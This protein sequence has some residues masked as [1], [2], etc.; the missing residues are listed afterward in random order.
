L[1]ENR[2]EVREF[3]TSRRARLTPDRV[4]LPIDLSGRDRRV[5]GLRRSEVAWIAGISAVYYTKLERGNL[6]G[7]SD[8]VLSAVGRALQLDEVE[9]AHLLALARAARNPVRAPVRVAPQRIRPQIQRI[10]DALVDSPA[11]VRNRRW[12][13]LAANRLGRALYAPVIDSAQHPPNM[14]R[15]LF[16]DPRAT[17]CFR[18]WDHVAD[19]LVARLRADLGQHPDDLTLRELVDEL[20]AGSKESRRRWSA[21]DA[22]YHHIGPKRLHH[23]I[24]GDFDF[25]YEA[26]QIPEDSGLTL[27]VYTAAPDSPT[28]EALS[29]LGDWAASQPGG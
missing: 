13:V 12:D 20:T 28:H 23:P 3:L 11:R 10:L 21:Q 14:A 22:C 16:L 17:V 18:E 19:A 2:D 4:D 29:L 24:V 6:A 25:T 1:V 26:L 8:S 27:L 15:F 5:E 9:Q 7:A